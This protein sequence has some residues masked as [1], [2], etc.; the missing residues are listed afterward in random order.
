MN[1]QSGGLGGAFLRWAL[2]AVLL[3]VLIFGIVGTQT[4]ATT[5][6]SYA[7]DAIGYVREH[8]WQGLLIFAAAQVLVAMSGALPASLLAVAAGSIYGAPG[9]FLVSALTTIVG[10][11]LALAVSRSLF[12]PGVERLIARHRKLADLNQAV[13]ASGWKFVCM[14]RVSPVMPFSATSYALG[15]S[16]VTRRDYLIGTLF[17]LPALLGYVA[18]GSL[19]EVALTAWARGDSPIRWLLIAIGGIATVVLLGWAVKVA[20]KLRLLEPAKAHRGVSR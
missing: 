3:S 9:G 12:R 4:S 5:L 18:M 10:A 17:S 19:A 14:L 20:I 2:A 11:D 7:E 6:L 1:T 16:Q 8:G 15:L 13:S